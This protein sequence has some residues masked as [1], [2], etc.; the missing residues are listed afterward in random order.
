[1][2]KRVDVI[3]SRTMK[4]AAEYRESFCRKGF[5]VKKN[6]AIERSTRR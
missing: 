2:A 6:R 1:M 4:P 3:M 5:L